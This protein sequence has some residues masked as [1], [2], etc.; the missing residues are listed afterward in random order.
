MASDWWL[1]GSDVGQLAR[2][3]RRFAFMARSIDIVIPSQ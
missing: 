2:S 1:I 3:G